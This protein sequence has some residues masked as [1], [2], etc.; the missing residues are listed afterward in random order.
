MILAVDPI[1]G[2]WL[3]V[4]LTALVLTAKAY[5]DARADRQVIRE[6]NGPVR[7][8]VAAG[9][10][11]HAG[12]LVIAHLLLLTV[13]VPGLSVDRAVVLT[14]T[15]AAL[16]AVPIVLLTSSVLDAR[17]RR[18]IS[19]LVAGDL[20]VVSPRMSEAA[21]ELADVAYDEASKP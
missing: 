8:L 18:R 7:E 3:A 16:V 6:T 11:R 17:D 2:I 19:F 10:V 9:F 20:A 21:G 1:E 13:V 12:L 4:N 15:V 5:L 14:P